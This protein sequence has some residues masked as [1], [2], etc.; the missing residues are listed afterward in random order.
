MD[1]L[2]LVFSRIYNDSST[3]TDQV[4]S[5]DA[6]KPRSLGV[7]DGGWK[8]DTYVEGRHGGS[9]SGDPWKICRTLQPSL[10]SPTKSSCIM[11][12]DTA[13][14]FFFSKLFSFSFTLYLL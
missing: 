13:A 6:N 1:L 14:L 2:F 8:E 11:T 12:Y 3:M 5:S 10:A 9:G 7:G 4:S